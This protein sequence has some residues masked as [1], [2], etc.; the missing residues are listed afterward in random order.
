MRARDFIIEGKQEIMHIINAIKEVAGRVQE[1][2]QYLE[3]VIEKP[4]EQITSQDIYDNLIKKGIPF[5]RAGARMGSQE[6]TRMGYNFGMLKTYAKW[7]KDGIAQ[8]IGKMLP[9]MVYATDPD[10]R[11]NIA[12]KLDIS[13]QDVDAIIDTY[14]DL[15]DKFPKAAKL[16]E[17]GDFE[18]ALDQV[19]A[20]MLE[21]I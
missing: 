6:L 4:L 5:A 10:M 14:E 11:K 13:E 7:N 9:D 19:I 15:A 3:Q 2:R 8:E 21:G 1:V 17:K 20:R 12:L 18:G 16:M